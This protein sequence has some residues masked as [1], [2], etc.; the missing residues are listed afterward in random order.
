MQ[1]H[2]TAIHTFKLTYEALPGDM[3]NAL[4]FWTGVLNGNGDGNVPWDNESKNANLHMAKAEIIPSGGVGNSNGD[5]AIHMKGWTD[6]RARVIYNTNSSI[7]D[8]NMIEVGKG[9]HAETEFLTAAEAYNIDKKIDDAIPDS[10]IM[11]H[12]T[13][14][15]SN[16]TVSN[17]YPISTTDLRCNILFSIGI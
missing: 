10:G 16:C 12:N 2:K 17:Q 3:S 4:D 14:Y 8:S 7:A 6:V 15:N 5:Y 9:Q 1:D 11:G 13:N